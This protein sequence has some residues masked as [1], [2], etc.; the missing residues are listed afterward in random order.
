MRPV[1]AKVELEW[2]LHNT[3]EGLGC[4]CTAMQEQPLAPSCVACASQSQAA[5]F[6]AL[7]RQRI[8][9]LGM[10]DSLIRASLCIMHRVA[11]F[12]PVESCW[13]EALY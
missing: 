5:L 12:L 8:S 9:V 2:F 6:T 7:I 11:V 4:V 3:C 1:Q 13:R 10:Q